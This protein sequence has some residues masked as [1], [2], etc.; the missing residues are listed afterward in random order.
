MFPLHRGWRSWAEGWCYEEDGGCTNQ[1]EIFT[2]VIYCILY[3]LHPRPLQLLST[4]HPTSTATVATGETFVKSAAGC[5]AFLHSPRPTHTHTLCLPLLTETLTLLQPAD[6]LHVSAS[7]LPHSSLFDS[8]NKDLK[9]G[10]ASCW[11]LLER[12]YFFFAVEIYNTGRGYI[13][14]YITTS[15][16]RPFIFGRPTS[17]KIKMYL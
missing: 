15:R 5:T 9:S 17:L 10:R 12:L 7:A 8:F 1:I 16:V 3:I 11:P 6:L 14:G 13:W 4:T 2:E